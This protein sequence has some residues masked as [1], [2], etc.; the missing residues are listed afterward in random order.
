MNKKVNNKGFT[1]VELLAVLVILTAIMGVAIPSISSSLERSK[2]KQNKA[3]EKVLVS[4]AELYI[5]D[6]KNSIY[7]NLGD[8]DTCYI[9]LSNLSAYIPDDVTKDADD[10]EMNGYIKFTKPN[11]YSYQ[12]GTPPSG[13]IE[14]SLPSEGGGAG[15]S[16]G[17]CTGSECF[18]QE[19]PIDMIE[20]F[21]GSGE[22]S[23][24]LDRNSS[25]TMCSS[26]SFNWDKLTGK[27]MLRN[28]ECTNFDT[29]IFTL[30]GEL[31]HDGYTHSYILSED[32]MTLYQI[33]DIQH[34][35]GSIGSIFYKKW[36]SVPK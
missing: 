5:T 9:Q 35:Y 15:G 28:S 2:N 31:S 34:R 29:Y 25:I 27:F 6:N 22:I 33:Y 11:S 17:I 21:Y 1:L 14:C 19:G 26:D 10:K 7:T 3:R 8:K 13:M 12:E 16:G 20:P 23:S 36:F 18:T 4:A 30:M 32:E 24:M